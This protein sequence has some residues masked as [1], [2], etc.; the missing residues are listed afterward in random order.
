MSAVLP[1]HPAADGHHGDHAH[2]H[3]HDHPTGWRRWLFA[4]NHKD[5]GTMYLIF[6]FIMLLQGGLLALWLRAELFQPGLQFT[7]PEFFNQL[8]TMHGIIMVFGAIMPAFVGFANW[9]IPLQIGASDMA[10]A[11]M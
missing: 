9:M 10:F 4:T 1:G 5:I 6:S 3:H 7:N 2:D 11:R 8:T